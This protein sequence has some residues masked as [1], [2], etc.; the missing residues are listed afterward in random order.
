MKQKYL[1][2]LLL[3]LGFKGA[4]LAQIDLGPD[5]VVC[6]GNPVTLAPVVIA[7]QGTNSGIQSDDIYG[8][9][10]NIGFSFTYFGNTYTQLVISSN[11]YL[12]FN[13][14]L[15]GGYS[16]WT[17]SAAI[18]S[19]SDP[20]NA[21]LGPWQDIL[22]TPAGGTIR[23][24][25]IGTAPNRVFVV[26]YCQVPMFS[27]TG[28][29]YTSQIKL[30]ETSNAI[31]TH[32]ET[33]P[34]CSTWNGGAAIHG[35]QNI[36]GTIAVVVPGRNYPSQW[37]T[38]NEGTRFTPNGPNS[39]TISSVPFLPESI[40][41]GTSGAPID[42]FVNGTTHA[43]SITS[44]SSLTVSPSVTTT[45][46]ARVTYECSNFVQWDSI[47]VS[48][49]NT[50]I[51]FDTLKGNNGI[52]NVSCFGG[53]DGAA[54]VSIN[55]S[56]QP[57]NL[58]WK[59]SAGNVIRTSN[60]VRPLNGNTLV[61]DSIVN[62]PVG[63]YTVEVT[64]SLNCTIPY[65]FNIQQP[66]VLAITP[67]HSDN[68]CF[69]DTTGSATISVSGGVA[70]YGKIWDNPR[71]DTT[72]A[73]SGLHAGI[74]NVTVTDF[75]GCTITQQFNI[76]QPL[77][78]DLT[79][80]NATDTCEKSVGT[81]TVSSFGGTAPYAYLW[82]KDSVNTQVITGLKLGT[83]DVKVTDSHGCRDSIHT[84]V[85]N[86]PSPVAIFTERVN[87]DGILDPVVA[88]DNS[89]RNSSIYNWNFG[90]GNFSTDENPVHTFALEGSYIVTLISSNI[91]SCAD[92][93]KD[94]V[95]I[96]PVF[97]FYI[98]DAFTPNGNGINDTFG[99]ESEGYKIDSYS[100]IIYDRW[101]EVVFRAMDLHD[102][103]DGNFHH[104]NTPAPKGVYVYRFDVKE[105]NGFKRKYVG[106][107]T[108]LR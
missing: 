3:L 21:I 63:I 103:W 1:L 37:T 106:Q 95:I 8:G 25:L 40:I 29:L 30:F 26:S 69:G 44:G 72:S 97:T 7:V 12:T 11:N 6:S 39:Y 91:Y 59:D 68:L 43:D 22:P 55:G 82:S 41:S 71:L 49:S 66:A 51:S 32:I 54:F 45:Y 74:Y 75:N 105:F 10:V 70:P 100:M 108:L 48:I 35:L 15:A 88:F 42:W 65:S 60:G 80:A 2:I 58:V 57:Y 9:V 23:Y 50:I 85:S 14:A 79:I 5:T 98:P 20:I 19:A 33:K 53:N 47:V 94:T 17:I 102:R 36:N 52:R 46:Y 92:T 16:P 90:D 18:P 67:A 86:I 101:G 13:T 62:Y 61:N 64:D 24:A 81:A 89:S 83:Y 87:P 99:P 78:L 84:Y 104:N 56:F 4:L 28:L 38:T 77:P 107:V 34:L 73:I 76:V 27:C 96:N 31:E 93:V